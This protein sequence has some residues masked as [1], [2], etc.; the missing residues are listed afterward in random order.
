MGSRVYIFFRNFCTII[1][2]VGYYEWLLIKRYSH[3]NFGFAKVDVGRWREVAEYMKINTGIAS[4]EL[5][6]VVLFERGKPILRIPTEHST[7]Q[8]AFSEVCGFEISN[9]WNRSK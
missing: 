7:T 3:P 5:P 6:T 8:N 4:K 1:V 2:K 9:C